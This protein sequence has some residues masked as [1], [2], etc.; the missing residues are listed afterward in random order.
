M[1]GLI[2]S[3]LL[4]AASI[5]ALMKLLKDDFEFR[6]VA[7]G[8]GLHGYVEEDGYRIEV[9]VKRD[10][11]Q[12]QFILPDLSI[13]DDV[14]KKAVKKLTAKLYAMISEKEMSPDN[15]TVVGPS[16]SFCHYCLEPVRELLFRCW[17]C[18]GLYCS[19]H[20][21]PEEHDCPGSGLARARLRLKKKKREKAEAPSR[22]LLKEA[23]CG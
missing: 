19:K 4:G 5:G 1:S 20:R 14:C 7:E 6:E 22:V 9:F 2:F 8:H 23:P 18:D 16:Y 10:E 12:V 15:V 3:L 11:K 13:P 21:F 17:R